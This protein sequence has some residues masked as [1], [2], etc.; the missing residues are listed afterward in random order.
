MVII[1]VYNNNDN[2][3]IVTIFTDNIDDSNDHII[4]TMIII[5]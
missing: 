1:V 2:A 4:T 3:N 5:W